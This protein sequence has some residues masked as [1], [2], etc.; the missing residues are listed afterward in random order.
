[1]DEGIIRLSTSEYASPIVL[2]KKKDGT[3]RVCIDYRKINL[4]MLRPLSP[5]PLIENQID[6]L[7]ECKYF[8]VIDLGNGF[9]HVWMDKDSIKCTAFVTPDDQYECLK[10][11]FSLCIGPSVF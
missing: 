6:A 11:P 10:L 7:A 2:I 9:F 1:M 4:I 5:L 8:T 3:F